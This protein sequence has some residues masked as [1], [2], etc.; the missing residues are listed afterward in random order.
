MTQR[1]KFNISLL[2]AAVLLLNAALVHGADPNADKIRMDRNPLEKRSGQKPYSPW[3]E[4]GF[5]RQVF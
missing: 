5:P 3:A 1:N 2:A 4:S